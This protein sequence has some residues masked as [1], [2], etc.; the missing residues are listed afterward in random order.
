LLA[1]R[2]EHG[3]AGALICGEREL[4]FSRKPSSR[5][6][7]PPVST[8]ALGISRLRIPLP[9]EH[10]WVQILLLVMTNSF[11]IETSPEDI[12]YSEEWDPLS[13]G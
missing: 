8:I 1:A 9:S 12:A 6:L 2:A 13:I 11:A 10:I 3:L 4:E 7:L 5:S